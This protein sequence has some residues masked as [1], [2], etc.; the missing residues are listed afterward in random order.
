MVGLA[1]LLAIA[2]GWL[3]ARSL[4]RRSLKYSGPRQ[5]WRATASSIWLPACRPSPPV[6]SPS[7]YAL[8]QPLPRTAVGDEVGQTAEGMRTIIARVEETI[9]AYER[10]RMQLH[11]LIGEVA[12]TAGKVD[13][14]AN[15]LARATEQIG[16]AST[17]IAR[18]IEEVARGAS[19]QSR[20]ATEAA[21]QVSEVVGTVSQV[22]Q[23]AEAQAQA[24]ARLATL[25]RPCERRWSA[26]QTA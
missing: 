10:A 11:D 13:G 22:A 23:G 7:R 15:Q 25:S 3:I 19:E 4:A 6:I 17:Q 5:V 18:A 24:A 8:A 21:S 2:L 14:G 12:T 26:P 9:E 16:Q 1:V 20:S